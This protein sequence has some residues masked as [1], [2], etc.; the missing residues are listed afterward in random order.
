MFFKMRLK[1]LSSAR[2]V[3][4]SMPHPTIEASKLG[5]FIADHLLLVSPKSLVSLA[6]ARPALKEQALSTLWSEQWS[7]DGDSYQKHPATGDFV[8]LPVATIGA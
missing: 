7:F 8:P 2:G 4:E 5:Q 6:C 3:S 1:E